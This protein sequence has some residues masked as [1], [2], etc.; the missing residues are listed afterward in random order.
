M[1]GHSTPHT[2]G[3]SPPRSIR[4]TQT[5]SM[6]HIIGV[7]LIILA[8]VA[9]GFVTVV[10]KEV[11]LPFVVATFLV[12]LMRP[13]VN[14]L[15]TPFS[16]W[17]VFFTCGM[18]TPPAGRVDAHASGGGGGGRKQS[19]TQGMDGSATE[20]KRHAHSRR[21][22]PGVPRAAGNS[23]AKYPRSLRS[24]ASWAW[25]LVAALWERCRGSGGGGSGGGS[26]GGGDAASSSSASAPIS[27]SS[28]SA[29]SAASS[30]ES[31]GEDC[32]I[33]CGR[34]RITRCPRW[35]SIL[36]ALTFAFS[37]LG[38][39]VLMVADAIQRFQHESLDA[40][41]G[42]A[43]RVVEKLQRWLAGFGIS[44]E[45]SA[46]LDAVKQQISVPFLVKT[47]VSVVVD[48][49]GNG[50][51]VLLLVLYLLAEQSTHA[52]GSLRARVDDQIQRYI[53]IKTMI[54]FM[55]GVLVYLIMGYFLQVRMAHLIAVL[56][57]ILNYIPTVSFP[58]PAAF[59]PSPSSLTHN[60]PTTH[61]TARARS[62]QKCHKPLLL[63][64]RAP[65]W[66]P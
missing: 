26:S 39:L 63:P 21:L 40:F 32:G 9:V 28:A 27:S 19:T 52:V 34:F 47:T 23:P 33:F 14:L 36:I 65:W 54:S 2:A 66:P 37:V 18:W 53:G 31:G 43:G 5:Q 51:L 12:Y 35:F 29:A 25:G 55:Q 3:W 48:G 7:P 10:L 24:V 4:G 6:L 56:H 11:L 41:V 13:L 59:A 64:R 58:P 42:E 20:S 15:S 30:V 57:F 60:T 8:C 61:N 1:R 62:K 45:G 44:L 50:L 38:A 22:A 17:C 49:L 46:I 16:W